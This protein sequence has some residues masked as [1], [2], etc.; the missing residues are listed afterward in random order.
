MILS[1][2]IYKFICARVRSLLCEYLW[3]A[4]PQVDIYTHSVSLR[5]R[6]HH[7]RRGQ[8]D[9]KNQRLAGQK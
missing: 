8:K 6:A 5:F 3:H 1:L 4:Y 2:W 7:G 9:C